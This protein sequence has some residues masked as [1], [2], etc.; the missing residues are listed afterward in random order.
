MAAPG[1][2]YQHT[3]ELPPDDGQEVDDE[4]WEQV[5]AALGLGDGPRTREER[6]ELLEAWRKSW[7]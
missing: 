7:S 4:Q 1:H 2:G 5:R 6:A 3:M